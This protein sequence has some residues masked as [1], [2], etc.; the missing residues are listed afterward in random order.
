MSSDV[1]AVAREYAGLRTTLHDPKLVK[2]QC[3]DVSK[4]FINWGQERHPHHTYELIHGEAPATPNTYPPEFNEHYAVLVNKQ[5][6]VDFTRRQFEPL[7]SV[8]SVM[9]VPDWRQKH[10]DLNAGWENRMNIRKLVKQVSEGQDPLKALLG[11]AFEH[12]IPRIVEAAF[13]AKELESLY[14]GDFDVHNKVRTFQPIDTG[15]GVRIKNIEV[16]KN[17]RD[18]GDR[19][20]PHSENSRIYVSTSDA[21][22]TMAKAFGAASGFFKGEG[23]A[24][25]PSDMLSQEHSG[26]STGLIQ[27]AQPEGDDSHALLRGFL[28]N[29]SGPISDMMKL[30]L[31]ENNPHKAWRDIVL[32]HVFK[33]LGMTGTGANDHPHA[34]WHKNAGCGTCPCSPGFIVHKSDHPLAKGHNIWVE[35]D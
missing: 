20:L 21:H 34:Q 25:T 4:D 16:Q 35:V 12:P 1:H 19:Q 14:G 7:A 31:P 30:R 13:S 22:R 10:P 5:H 18:R 9:S 33:H 26:E 24:E 23:D 29:T 28:S 32:P 17:I 15:S 8:P 27:Q 11:E 6:V 3:Y 2:D